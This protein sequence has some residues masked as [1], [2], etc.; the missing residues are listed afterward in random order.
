[1]ARFVPR[2]RLEMVANKAYWDPKRTPKID[3]VVLLPM[4][5]ANARTAALLS[6]QV[7]WIE[8]PSPDAMAQI[9]SAASRSTATRS[10]T[11]GPGS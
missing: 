1:M 2:E 3:R 6:G 8:A 5:E 4:P 7:D 9:R 11:C 10:R